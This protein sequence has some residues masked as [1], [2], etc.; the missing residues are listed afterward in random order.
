MAQSS[1]TPLVDLDRTVLPDAG[2]DAGQDA[3]SSRRISELTAV[4]RWILLG[5]P[6]SGKSTVFQQQARRENTEAITARKFVEGGRPPGPVLFVDGVEEYR[7]GQPGR[8]RWFD[9][10]DALATAPY[11]RWRLACRAISV[12]P[13][14]L[15][16][17]RRELGAV[18]T[19]T[20]DQLQ[21]HEQIAVLAAMGEADPDGFVDRL[22]AMGSEALLGNPATLGLVVRALKAPGPALHS[23]GEVFK[24]AVEEMAY[25]VNEELPERAD[26]PAASAMLD[27][28]ERACLVTM[29]STRDELWLHQAR[30]PSDDVVTKSDLLP[31]EVDT[32]ALLFAVDTQLFRAE[33][34]RFL[35][36][37][38]TVAEF[39]AGR[40]LAR[41]V[42]RTSGSPP[43]L[44]LRRALALLSGPDGHPAPALAGT[45]A[46]FVSLLAQGSHAEEAAVL[47]D[48][49][50]ELVLAQGDPALLP[51][52]HRRIV[53]DATGRGDPWFLR[54]LRGSSAVGGLAS[55]DI[56]P[57]LET[58]LLDRRETA[59]RRLL[60]L[61]ALRLGRPLPELFN[62][63]EAVARDPAEPEWLRRRAVT[64]LIARAKDA[65]ARLR[66][67]ADAISAETTREGVEVRLAVMEG[68]VGRGAS[69]EES[70][71]VLGAYAAT[72]DGVMG[73]A[74]NLGAALEGAPPSDFF[75]APVPGYRKAL[76]RARSFEVSS[77]IQQVLA[78]RIRL[79][80]AALTPG[81]LLRWLA[82]AGLKLGADPER[83]VREAIN[84]WG[85]GSDDRLL[86][87]FEALIA[88]SHRQPWQVQH[89]FGRLTGSMPPP[90]PSISC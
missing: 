84:A 70:R 49:N 20:L 8:D 51:T 75:E 58:I 34:G 64:V 7:I 86:R 36:T 17:L 77:I 12:P 40:G 81:T 88:R 89:E 76:G 24:R 42:D 59:N 46:W 1:Q 61:E 53:L 44:P 54:A 11:A 68:L 33:G 6:G 57:E 71:A 13:P 29:L 15:A 72:G 32:A 25:E 60:I 4:T 56:A 74:R 82:N 39:L 35:P 19:W 85:G 41:A 62:S 3:P 31:A 65:P 45:F 67:L 5:E 73:Y 55:S 48:A 9:L 28:A 52:R 87:L 69:S 38:R 79:D 18:E 23:R 47:I 21:R 43:A 14:D 2:L 83:D 63:V 66:R 26:R 50:P 22:E 37:H 78:A 90:L 10:I 16:V 30:P 80:G 27:A